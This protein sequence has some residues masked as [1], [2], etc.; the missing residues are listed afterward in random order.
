MP[1]FFLCFS[2]WPAMKDVSSELP[3]NSLAISSVPL[4]LSVTNLEG[5]KF[6]FLVGVL[7]VRDGLEFCDLF[8]MSSSGISSDRGLGVLGLFSRDLGVLLRFCE[9]SRDFTGVLIGLL[10]FLVL[11]VFRRCPWLPV[12]DVG[13][14]D[15]LKSCLNC[16]LY[17]SLWAGTVQFRNTLRIPYKNNLKIVTSIKTLPIKRRSISRHL[18]P[19]NR[20]TWHRIPS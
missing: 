6:W 10:S 13:E 2:S 7:K 11:E 20:A 8:L 15:S 3:V 17:F 16:Q 12:D 19:T 9:P 14:P 4:E 18:V 1:P 5:V